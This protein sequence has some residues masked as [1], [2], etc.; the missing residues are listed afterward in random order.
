MMLPKE[1]YSTLVLDIGRCLRCLRW[2]HEVDTQEESLYWA[3]RM[4]VWAGLA[5]NTWMQ[6]NCV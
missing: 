3:S 4:Y 2:M 5:L 1:T 6:E